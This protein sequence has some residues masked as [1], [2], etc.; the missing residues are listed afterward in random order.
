MELLGFGQAAALG[1]FFSGIPLEAVY[2]SPLLRARQTAQAI[3]GNTRPLH[4]LDNLIE[5]DGGEWDGLTF[6]QLR[7]RYPGSFGPH[8]TGTCPP[9][10]ESDKDGLAR[11]LAAL[12]TVGT[13]TSSCAAIVAHSGVNR[14]LLCHLSGLA[15][16]EKKKMGQDHAGAA[17]LQYK[18]GV[19]SIKKRSIAVY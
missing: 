5:L 10:G 8:A 2:A 19:W 12:E 13:H 9:G 4:I 11:M 7:E 6:D 15:T 18:D 17:L 16:T 14:L 1:R 3:A